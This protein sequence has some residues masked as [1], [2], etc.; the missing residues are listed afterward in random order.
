[1]GYRS[2]YRVLRKMSRVCDVL[3]IG[4]EMG[5]FNGNRSQFFNG[6]DHEGNE[7]FS[8]A[9]PFRKMFLGSSPKRVGEL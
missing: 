6:K 7:Y 3:V 8:F 9:H 2:A 5:N 1:M 4:D